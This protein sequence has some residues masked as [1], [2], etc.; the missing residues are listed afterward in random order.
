MPGK[1]NPVICESVIQVAVKVIAHDSAITYGGFGGVGSILELNVAMPVMAD[2]MM[3][4]IKLL[5]HVS[6]VFVDKLLNGL[7][8]NAKRCEQLI[9]QSLMMC[10][11]LAPEIGYDA[12]AKLAK[13]AFV[14]GKTIRQL[15]LEQRLLPEERLSELLNPDMMTRPG[16]N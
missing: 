8:V 3:E 9:D 14:E 6:H 4:S 5:A 7:E 12:A 10:T 15:A 16:V 1:V 13:Q 2:A 11:S